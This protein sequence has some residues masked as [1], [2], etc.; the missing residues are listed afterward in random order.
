MSSKSKKTTNIDL[1]YFLVEFY[2]FSKF[3]NLESIWSA[4]VSRDEAG[5]ISSN[6]GVAFDYSLYKTDQSTGRLVI[7]H[8]WNG[9]SWMTISSINLSISLVNIPVITNQDFMVMNI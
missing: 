3:H 5:S 1:M 8:T 4:E 2:M 9:Q 7:I 6:P